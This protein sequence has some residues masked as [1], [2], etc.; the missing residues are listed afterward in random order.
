MPRLSVDLR[1]HVAAIALALLFPCVTSSWAASS[2]EE[3]CDVNADFVLGHEDYPAAI[4]LHRKVLQAHNDSALAHYHLGFAYGMTGRTTEEISEYLAAV[5]LRLHKW[6]LFLN[7]GLAYLGQ[8]D[9]PKAIKTLQTA[10]LLG[11][12][13]PETHFNLAIAYERSNKLREALQEITTSLV[14]SPLDPDENNTKAIICVELGDVVC[15]RREWAHLVE[16]APDYT[17][18]RVNL[19]ILGG[20]HVPLAA[21]TSSA[22]NA[23]ALEFVR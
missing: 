22:L 7:L 1:L 3:I 9:W 4:A 16:V 20:S 19:A 18:A 17:P 14:L 8:N 2:Q 15:A 21:S 23:S 5:G 11:P 13:H 10:V 6:D 12:D